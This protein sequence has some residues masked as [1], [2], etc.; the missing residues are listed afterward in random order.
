M[1]IKIFRTNIKNIEHS[2]ILY[3]YEKSQIFLPS[4][5]SAIVIIYNH[6]KYLKFISFCVYL[7]FHSQCFNQ[8]CIKFIN[9]RLYRVLRCHSLP[10]VSTVQCALIEI[11]DQILLE[12]RIKCEIFLRIF[13]DFNVETRVF[14]CNFFENFS[15]CTK[16]L[17]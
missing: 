9:D 17:N 2:E 8:L 14:E 16:N 10:I 11:F 5:R 13:I 6:I 1:A 4:G 7:L 15:E 12:D 3:K